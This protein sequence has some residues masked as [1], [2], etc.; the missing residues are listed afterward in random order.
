MKLTNGFVLLLLVGC[1]SGTS[2]IPIKYEFADSPEEQRIELRFRN[3]SNETLCLLPEAW[4]NSGGM[5][6]QGSGRVFLVVDGKRFPIA[7]SLLGYCSPPTACAIHV[8]PGEEVSASIPY[9][10]F[11]IPEGLMGLSKTLEFS[12][13]AVECR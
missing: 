5:I 4:P 11:S 1:V 8:S 12:T 3:N 13:V 6:Y 10:N 9:R 2:I 7:E